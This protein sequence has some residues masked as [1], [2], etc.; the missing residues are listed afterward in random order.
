MS[1]KYDVVIIGAG[2][3]GYPA[4][5]RASQ[6]GKKV[7][8][9]DKGTIGG[10]CLNW[11]CI[12]SKAM[13]SAANFYYKAKTESNQ[14]GITIDTI[15][16][17]FPKLKSWKQSIQDKLIGGIKQLLKANKIK[18][19][20][21]T[22]KLL[23]RNQLSITLN[24]GG[25]QIIDFDSLIIATG[26][27]FISLP[28]FEIDETFILSSKGLFDLDK[29]PE[30]LI[31]VGGGIIGIELGTVFAKLGSNVKVVELLPQLL[32]GIDKR[33][34]RQV[35]KK[36]KTLGVEVYTEAMGKSYS[37]KNGKINLIIETKNGE[38][39]ITGDKIL[40]SVGKKASTESLGL[41]IAGVK[42]DQKGFI[43]VDQQQK[44]N[45]PNIYAIGDCT[46]LPFLA[47]KATKQG[48]IASEVIAGK[49]SIADFKSIPSAIFTDPEIA[50]AGLTEAEAKEKGLDVMIGQAAFAASGRAM[51][52]MEE[53]GFVKVISDANDG[54][55]LGV[56]I[57][58]PH[59]SDLISE[60]ALA[61]EMG[62]T[63][64][65]I[66]FTVHP[67]PTLPEMLME[68]AEAIEGKA[69]HVPNARKRK[70]KKN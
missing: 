25:E 20:L 32:T 52:I 41:E 13:I 69:I 9:I 3:G 8:I 11:G 44:T 63:V 35:D 49:N 61:L 59:A 12:P 1:E 66:G 48:I 31:C 24:E 7:A 38:K 58:G 43:I 37:I 21:G 27:Q 60:A 64:E 30:E 40:L 56:E 15:S 55:L 26:T 29:L 18:T 16:V 68:A 14:M 67:H 22:A 6:L 10:E 57:V 42:L 28:G 46:G 54:V 45:I 4:A 50:I 36:L 70:K 65:D 23:N 5:I 34:V 53:D 2:P 33:L 17:D 62:A 51:S 39:V 47:H 19:I